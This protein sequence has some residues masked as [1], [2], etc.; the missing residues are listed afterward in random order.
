MKVIRSDKK[1]DDHARYTD[2]QPY[3]KRVLDGAFVPGNLTTQ[4]KI[5]GPK[6]KPDYHNRQNDVRHQ[7]EIINRSNPA[8]PT[9]GSRLMREVIQDVSDQK[10]G[11]ERERCQ[12][13]APVRSYVFLPN[14]VQTNQQQH[15]RNGVYDAV[16]MGQIIR[17]ATQV[18]LLSNT[19]HHGNSKRDGYRQDVDKPANFLLLYWL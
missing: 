16:D 19:Q 8:L 18:N 9:K 7:Q 14:E 3:W 5:N 1:I 10:N 13:G 2:V 12:H 15:R 4:R 6:H 17:P 11:P